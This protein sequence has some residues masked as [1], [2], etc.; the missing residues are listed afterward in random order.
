MGVH[1]SSPSGCRAP[2]DE[3]DQ[4]SCLQ[5]IVPCQ[6]VLKTIEVDDWTFE[7]LIRQSN[8]LLARQIVV[9]LDNGRANLFASCLHTH[10]HIHTAPV[11]IC[12]DPAV[13]FVG[14]DV[15]FNCTYSFEEADPSLTWLRDGQPL[16]GV[17]MEDLVMG[18]Q[19]LLEN[20]P[21]EWNGSEITCSVMAG[22]SSGAAST[23]LTV[24]CEC[25]LI[26]RQHV[27]WE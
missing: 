6:S 22:S 10:T 3:S 26:L 1:E 4:S 25:C 8:L 27:A 7:Y 17:I 13:T 12:P 24:Y 16:M 15:E 9:I 20:V 11:T 19:L 5:S 18:G 23:N 21:L 14:Q 2:G